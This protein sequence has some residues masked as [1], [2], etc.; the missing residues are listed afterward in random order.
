MYYAILKL[1]I[2]RFILIE[3]SS[4]EQ[5][6]SDFTYSYKTFEMSYMALFV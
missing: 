2:L 3:N 1:S 6:N 5:Y 4:T